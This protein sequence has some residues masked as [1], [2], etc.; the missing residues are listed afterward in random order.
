MDMS[1]ISSIYNT[2]ADASSAASDS[3]QNS[4][5]KVSSDSSEDELK[6]VIKDFDSYFVEQVLK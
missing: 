6:S 2:A 1:G 3:L 5:K 4:L